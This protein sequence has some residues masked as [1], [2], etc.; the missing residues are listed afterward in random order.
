MR[1]TKRHNSGLTD[2]DVTDEGLYKRRREFI[3]AGVAGAGLLAT[4]G[5]S[6]KWFWESDDPQPI[7][8][9]RDL[10]ELIKSPFSTDEKLNSFEDITSYCNFYELGTSKAD[11]KENA[12]QLIT[13]PWTVRITGECNKPGDYNLEDILK[14]HALEERIYRL[15]CVEAWSMVVPW[16]GFPLADLIKHFEPTGNAKFVE[17]RT[18]Y[19]PKRLPG[20]KW[21]VLDWPY[22]EGLR[23]DEAM[24][25]LTLMAVGLY[26]KTIP[27]QNGAPIRLV[28]PWKYGFKSSKSIVEIRFTETE[29]KNTW[30]VSSPNEYGFY[31]NVNPAVDHPRW[32]QARERRIGEF[33]KQPTLPFNGYADQ[34]ASLYSGMDLKKHF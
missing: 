30:Q 6:A 2:N 26:G 20:Q 23:M 9:T 24:N 25:P 1:H 3:K 12:H 7:P 18:L 4:G 32:S 21:P 22:V 13:D 5:L 10:G 29:P 15:R 14:P 11:P 8:D 19:D 33:L 17:F 28:V 34:V 27:N 16:V 31:A